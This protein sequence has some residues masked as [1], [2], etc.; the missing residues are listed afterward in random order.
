MLRDLLRAPRRAAILVIPLLFAGCRGDGERVVGPS[1]GDPSELIA[2]V[3]VTP[4]KFHAGE[5]VQ[6]EVG[7]RN[8]TT[9]PIV[10]GFTSGSCRTSY[11]VTDGSEVV[12]PGFLC[13]GDAPTYE[14]APGESIVGRHSWDGAS[15][16]GTPLPPGKYRVHSFGFLFPSTTPVR[17]EILAP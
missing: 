2:W 4:T 13:T 11:V 3:S 16:S 8:S 14:L 1:F 17:I 10:M 12:A 9:R 15:S 7:V 5:T 6:I